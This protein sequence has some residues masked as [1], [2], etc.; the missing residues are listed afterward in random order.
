L[1]CNLTETRYQ[2]VARYINGL[3]DVIQDHLMLQ[4]IW[5]LD[6][7]QAQS[8]KAE[9]LVRTIK[10]SKA[11]LTHTEGLPRSHYPRVEEKTPQSKAK[12]LAQSKLEARVR[13][14]L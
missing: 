6:Q 14:S 10:E 9:R 8:L 4:Q 7:A 1:R 13:Q 12:Q 3:N 2:Q 5:S 11:P